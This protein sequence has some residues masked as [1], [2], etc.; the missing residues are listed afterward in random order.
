MYLFY[1]LKGVLIASAIRFSPSHYEDYQF[2]QWAQ[3]CGWGL[4]ALPLV[5][6]FGTAIIQIIRYGVKTMHCFLILIFS[7]DISLMFDRLIVD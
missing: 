3:N 1:C 5:F 6:L 4:V 2:E 7:L